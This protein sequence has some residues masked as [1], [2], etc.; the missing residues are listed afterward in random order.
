MDFR[1]RRRCVNAQGLSRRKTSEKNQTGKGSS[2]DVLLKR[3]FRAELQFTHRKLA[4][5]R[6]KTRGIDD[7]GDLVV[8][9]VVQNVERLAR[10]SAPTRSL[11]RKR[12]LS[13]V[14]I[15]KRPGPTMRVSA[16]SAELISRADRRTRWC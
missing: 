14:S 3:Y 8:V 16:E 10:I 2:H 15:L 11:I 6:S 1:L 7:A 4:L 5:H 13:V 9:V 12:L